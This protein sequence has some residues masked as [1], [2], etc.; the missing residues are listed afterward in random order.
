MNRDAKQGTS[1]CSRTARLKNN[2]VRSRK[3]AFKTEK[4]TTRVL[5]LLRK[6]Y[7][8][9]FCLARL[10]AVRTSEKERTIGETRGGKIWDQIR[11]VR[12]T[13]STL[14]RA[15][16]RKN[17]RPSLGKYKSKFVTYPLVHCDDPRQDGTSTEYHSS[18]LSTHLE[19]FSADASV[20]GL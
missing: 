1:L 18:T 2:Q 13:Q 11:W 4:A 9:W 15:S 7:L 6:L 12:F 20:S 3:R 10:R 8:N 16:I 14:R 19:P 5:W 17:K